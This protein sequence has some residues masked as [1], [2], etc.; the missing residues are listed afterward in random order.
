[1]KLIMRK[2]I[3]RDVYFLSQIFLLPFSNRKWDKIK[4]V[5]FERKKGT[6]LTEVYF[7]FLK[8]KKCFLTIFENRKHP[9]NKSPLSF[10]KYRR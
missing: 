10:E 5:N 4:S 9:L 7:F 8:V 3:F 1:M 2:K 6:N